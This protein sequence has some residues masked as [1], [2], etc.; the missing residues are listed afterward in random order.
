MATRSILAAAASAAS[1]GA[2]CG[3]LL[4]QKDSYARECRARVIACVP[5]PAEESKQGGGKKSKKGKKNKKAAAGGAADAPPAG[6]LYDVVLTDTVLFPEGGGQPSDRGTVGGVPCLRCE[7]V[8][9]TAV[10]VLSGP[11]AVSEGEDAGDEV[12]VT[13]DWSRRW[14]HMTQHSAQHLVTAL[15]MKRW[16]YETTSWNLGEE[17]SFLELGTADLHEDQKRELEQAANEAIRASKPVL[18]SWHSVEDVNGGNV[19]GLRVSSKALP[20]SVTGPVRVVAFEGI[21]T[22]SCCGTHVQHTGHLQAVKLL[23]AE[24]SKGSVKL[25]FLAGKRV[26]KSLGDSMERQTK[27]G[28]VLSVGP[29]DLVDRVEDLS[30]KHRAADKAGK[31]LALELV[32]LFAAQIKAQQRQQ[33]QQQQEEEEAK[34]EKKKPGRAVSFCRGPPETAPLGGLTPTEFLKALAS[35]VTEETDLVLIAAV[36][37][38]ADAAGKPVAGGSFVVAAQAA[39]DVAA[40]GKAVAEALCGRGGGKGN[41]FQGKCTAA[42]PP[43]VLESAAAA[44]NEA[45]TAAGRE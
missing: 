2:R 26:L 27:L 45:L 40:A 14:D 12:E 15:A 29:A 3:E 11:L 35:A 20:D 6:D 30:V 22:N 16:G 21:D 41:R 18:P 39:E 17:A 25:W 34:D 9:G 37:A 10:H 36:A 31:A 32:D 43:E 1:R 13:V 7:N 24:K 8:D 33:Q 38:P 28:A 44:A 42:L 19:P 4:C 5:H 23:K